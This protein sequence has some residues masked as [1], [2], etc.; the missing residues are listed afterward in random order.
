MDWQ[1]LTKE[2]CAKKLGTNIKT[3]LSPSQAEERRN[4][5]GPNELE[6]PKKKS[7]LL[8]FFAQ[9][10]DFMVI[11]LLVAAGISFVTSFLQKDND[12]IDSIIILA[13]VTVNAMTGLIQESRAEKSIEALKK[14]SSPHAHVVRAGT[15]AL[16][17]AK[18]LVPGDLVLLNA[19]DLVP[20]DLRLTEA[21]NLKAEESALTGESLPSRKRADMTCSANTPLG[22]RHNLLFSSSSI[23]SGHGAGIVTAIGMETQVGK[24]AHMIS[25]QS[26]PQT[27]LQRKLAQ[28]GRWL[29]IGALAICFVIF[30]MGLFQHVQPLEMFLIAISL[31][32]AAI[33]EGLPAVVT[34]VLAIGVRRMAAKRSIVRRMPAVETLGSASVIC[35]D[36]TGTLTQNRMTVVELRSSGG[37]VPIHSA[38]G[39]FLLSLAS[40][41]CNCTVSGSAIHGDPT[42]TAIVSAAPTE[43][44][45]LDEQYPRVMEIPFSSERKM[46]TTVHRLGGGRYRIITKGAPDILFTHCTGGAPRQNEEMASRALRVI[47]V[48]YRDIDFLPDPDEEIE[49]GL[50]FCGL[51][52]MIDPPR[53][54]VK[55]A[56]DLCRKAGIRPIMITGDHAATAAAIAKQLG[57]MD[58]KSRVITGA[59]L[60]RLSQ[61]ELERSIYDYAV[62]ARV[63]PEHKVRIVRAF[64]SR[65]EVVAMTGDGVND[66]PALRAAD[67]GCAMGISGTDVAKAASDMVLTDDNFATIVAAV[68]EGRG[69][70][71]NIR[72][73]VHFLLSCNIGEILTVFV[74]FLLRLPTPLL[75]IQLL[76]V[77]LVT[78][79][80][81]ALAL[82]VE[83]IDKDIMDRK[84]VK[85]NESVFSGGMGYNIIVEGCLIGAIS[86][87]A[88]SIGRIYFDVDPSAPYVGRTMAF[89]VLSL[90]QIV[91]TF[92]M[93]SPHSVFKAGIFA[94]PKLVM[95]GM[96]CTA[97]QAMVIVFEPL[98][99]IFKT[100]VLNGRQ[101]LIVALL[102]LIPLAVVELE[103][104][105][106]ARKSR[107]KP[108]QSGHKKSAVAPKK[109]FQGKG[110]AFLN[111]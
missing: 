66:A 31:A 70:Y 38:Q 67:I 72:K 104:A 56:V 16:I 7:V 34:I 40:L 45:R 29:G 18:N 71:E 68:R 69:I 111:R 77:N 4:R 30:I 15:E 37:A 14:M 12:Y 1:S 13:I 42:E 51:I 48:A 9:F 46:M 35:S 10:S 28:T 41:C 44:K 88:Y 21:V 6:Q 91:H 54:Q 98:A 76:W 53:P 62:F 23:A 79:S 39:D 24:I 110:K 82:G 87:L 74:S 89:A 99:V 5:Y 75:A 2:E 103:K 81:P 65:G 33:P 8:R 80:L 90:S 25:T 102:S 61:Q 22:D 26:A 50:T 27:P 20:A 64:Q 57:I 60:D 93:R 107:R 47:G 92:N 73:T 85:P 32:V 36:K 86:L 101:W 59:E 49:H 58:G 84:P 11:I 3:G 43:K 96:I 83:P 19:G 97:L 95:A 108:T 94:N 52:G 17:E 55:P 109:S 105:V 100:A 106:T 78:D 63:S